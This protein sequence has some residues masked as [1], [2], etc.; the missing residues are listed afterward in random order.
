MSLT[1]DFYWDRISN[2]QAEAKLAEDLDQMYQDQLEDELFYQD[3]FE[4]QK[5][6][7]IFDVTNTYP[8]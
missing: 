7:D 5:F 8:I 2:E 3:M 4:R 6:F 1:K